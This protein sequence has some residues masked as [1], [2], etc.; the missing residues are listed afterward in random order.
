MPPHFDEPLPK[1]EG[2]SEIR[3]SKGFREKKAGFD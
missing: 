1:I 2:H 3:S